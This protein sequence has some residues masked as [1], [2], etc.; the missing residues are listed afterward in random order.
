MNK[1]AL[2][3]GGTGQF[4]FYIAKL[5]LQKRYKVY[6]STRSFKN[7]KLNK[8]RSLKTKINF[9]KINILKNS[10]IKNKILRI[11][12]YYI[13]YLAGQSSVFNSFYKKKETLDSNFLGCK[14]F[15]DAIFQLKLDV[16]FFNASSSEIFGNVAKKI[17]IN[18]RKNPISP[19]ADAKLKSFKIVKKY[20][21]IYNLKVY[22]G[23]IFN[24]ESYLRPDN[25]IVPK[26]CHSAIQSK[27]LFNIKKK[28]II[29][30]GN[31][32]VYRDWGWCEEYAS[33]IWKYLQKSPQD[34]I[35]ATGKTFSVKKLLHEAFSFFKLN[36]KDYVII[37][38]SLFRKKEI[39]SS[40]AN[41]NQLKKD[42]NYVPSINGINIV[43][44]IIKYYLKNI[45]KNKSQKKIFIQNIKK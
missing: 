5:L 38:K 29:K 43:R 13:F 27:K 33:I 10:D 36:W 28:K 7:H 11:S 32:N 39:Y 37:D 34:F 1:T 19:Y 15:L 35:V 17:K 8:F 9:I 3:V 40:K 4:G 14:K 24:C 30:F 22:N 23:V 2:I 26:I 42:I 45:Y 21:K 41:I 18:S 12:P 31:I 25:F 44:K 16:K 6:I 20:R